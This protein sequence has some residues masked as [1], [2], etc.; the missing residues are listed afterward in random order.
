MRCSHYW[1]L[2]TASTVTLRARGMKATIKVDLI[3][4]SFSYIALSFP[5]LRCLVEMRAAIA[6]CIRLIGN[7]AGRQNEALRTQGLRQ[8]SVEQK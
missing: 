6:L 7:S 4:L 2:Y 3:R 8:W 1:H 5:F